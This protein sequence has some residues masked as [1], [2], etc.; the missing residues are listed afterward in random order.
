VATPQ[1]PKPIKGYINCGSLN[2]LSTSH[3]IETQNCILNCGLFA[4]LHADKKADR[5]DHIHSWFEHY[6]DALE[7]TGWLIVE[8]KCGDIKGGNRYITIQELITK[9][10]ENI[11]LG[12]EHAVSNLINSFDD[13]S[14]QNAGKSIFNANSRLIGLGKNEQESSLTTANFQMS[15]SYNIDNTISMVLGCYQFQSSCKC[16]RI[17]STNM[18]KDKITIWQTI[19]VL[20]LNEKYYQQVKVKIENLIKNK[21]E[22]YIFE[23][24]L[25]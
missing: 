9:D 20:T 15:Y 1:I 17:F 21:I 19:M 22:K 2:G 7:K 18:R 23:L 4:Q 11:S 14:P 24:S 12:S 6:I 8:Q 10:F 3:D 5:F 13:T 25:T 16:N